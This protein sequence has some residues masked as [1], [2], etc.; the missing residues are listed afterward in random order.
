MSFLVKWRACRVREGWLPCLLIWLIVCV[1]SGL[2]DG[3][4]GKRG[5]PAL[6]SDVAPSVC[7]FWFRGG[8]AE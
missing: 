1:V 8:L 3:L 4:L 6:L 5:L 2:V 7:P